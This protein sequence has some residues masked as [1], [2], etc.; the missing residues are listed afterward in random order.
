M[1]TGIDSKLIF[2]EKDRRVANCLILSNKKSFPLHISLYLES[3]EREQCG[4]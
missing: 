4:K 3:L 1:L 2:F